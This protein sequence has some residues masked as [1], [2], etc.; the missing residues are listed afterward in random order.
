MSDEGI[1]YLQAMRDLSL[2]PQE[3]N[4]YAHHLDNLYGRGKVAQ[5]GG[6]ISTVLQAVV[7]GP[8]GYYNIPTVWEGKV[9]SVPEA[10][11]RAFQQGWANFPKY[12]SPE[13]ADARYQQMHYY[14]NLDTERYQQAEAQKGR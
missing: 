5:P 3:Q 4:I 8:G 7:Y 2:S 9:L 11:E 1:P 14:M 12:A 6:E 13:E 10:R